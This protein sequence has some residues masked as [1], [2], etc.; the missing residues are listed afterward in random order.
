MGERDGVRECKGEEQIPGELHREKHLPKEETSTKI[1]P[2]VYG[3]CYGLTV[4]CIDGESEEISNKTRK[5]PWNQIMK[6]P[7]CYGKFGPT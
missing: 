3:M 1:C 4:M 7:E 5:V 2:S 6:I